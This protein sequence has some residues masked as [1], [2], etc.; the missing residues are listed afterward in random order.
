MSF[1][2]S[3]AESFFAASAAGDAAAMAALCADD[4]AVRQNSGPI[5]GVAAVTGLARA[6]KRAAP[7]FRYENPVRS[8]TGGGFVEE[9]D[10]C[11]TLADGTS[12]RVAVCV[13][14][15]VGGGRITSMH[16][17]L[18]TAEAKPLFDALSRP[19]A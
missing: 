2:T 17:Y 15:T 3:L 6:V 14:A 16:E 13:V 18:D 1:N 7:D 19:R 10:V 9:H 4:I 11:G 8:D 5:L 12:F